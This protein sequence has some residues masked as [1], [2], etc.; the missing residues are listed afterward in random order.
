MSGWAGTG[1]GY[2]PRSRRLSSALAQVAGGVLH[3]VAA[4]GKSRFMPE[5]T[6]PDAAHHAKITR[7]QRLA[8]RL[9][10]NLRRRKAQ[11]RALSGATPETGAAAGD[12]DGAAQTAGTA[13]ESPAALSKSSAKS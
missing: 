5:P 12:E 13:Q 9:R 1:A 7:E 2:C 11:A 8:A 6:A 4:R 3:R 10:D